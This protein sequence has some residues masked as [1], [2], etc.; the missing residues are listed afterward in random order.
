M[1]NDTDLNIK[2]YKTYIDH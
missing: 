2:W 1:K